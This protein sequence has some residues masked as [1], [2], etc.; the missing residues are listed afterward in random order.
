MITANEALERL[1]RGNKAYLETGAATGDFSE[2]TRK[3][4][5][6]GQRPY[7]VIIA[8]ADSRV[9]PE[10]IFSAGIG[11]LFVIREAGNV[12]GHHEFG[13]IEYAISHLGCELVVV[14][15]HTHCGAIHA[16]IADHSEGHTSYLIDKIQEAIGDETDHRVAAKLNALA[17]V[18]RIQ[19]VL[20]LLDFKAVAA[21]YDIETG[22]VE[23]V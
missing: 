10:A 13:S 16:A 5:A 14:L 22:E 18:A 8:C 23:W 19:T 4:T 9:V 12:I 15:G 11:E 7:A 21:V 20:S 6:P 2:R 1:I 3:I 17:G